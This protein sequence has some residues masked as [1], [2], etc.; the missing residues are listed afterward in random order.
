MR[1]AVVSALVIIAVGAGCTSSD[2]ATPE[3][4]TEPTGSD[5]TTSVDVGG[6]SLWITCRGEGSPTIVTEAGYDSSGQ[7]EWFDL[8]D[9]LSEISRV[10]AYDRA[11]TGTSDARPSNAT[12]TSA[13]QAEELH[14][15]LDGAGVAGPFVLL[16][17]SYGGFVA[18][19]F[20]A[21]YRDETAGLILIDSSHEDEIEPYHRY[22]GNDPEG[23]W[24]DGGTTIDIDRTERLLRGTARDYGDVP[25]VAIQAAAY[26]DV[27]SEALWNRTQADLATL[28]GDGRLVRAGRGGHNVQSDDPT[29]VLAIVRAVVAT[30]RDG[31]QLPACHDLV[32]GTDGGCPPGDA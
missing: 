24:V 10:C 16:A 26:E 29:L 14:R 23:A 27:L 15:V 28:S 20:A 8:L 5:M 12:I 7:D 6:Y 30:A 11:G 25:L 3:P 18:R 32:A 2:G 22:Y 19:L 17:H 13:D 1:H 31:S 21:A 4:S 9:P